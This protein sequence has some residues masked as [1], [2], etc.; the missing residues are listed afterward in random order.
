MEFAII[1]LLVFIVWTN[2][3][4]FGKSIITP[5]PSKTADEKFLAALKDYLK[6]G[7]PVRNVDK[8]EDKK[9]G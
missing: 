4:L 6:E 5:V 9:G 2:E 3:A 7:I 1:L 8:K